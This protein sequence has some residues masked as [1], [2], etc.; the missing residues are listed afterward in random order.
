MFVLLPNEEHPQFV[1]VLPAVLSEDLFLLFSGHGLPYLEL[2]SPGE[3]LVLTGGEIHQVVEY[4]LVRI[5]WLQEHL[6]NLLF[7]EDQLEGVFE[8]VL[9][10]LPQVDVYPLLRIRE[11]FGLI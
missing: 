3:K 11:E 6:T 1:F 8:L 9:V 10:G 7:E 5:I 2:L 4:L